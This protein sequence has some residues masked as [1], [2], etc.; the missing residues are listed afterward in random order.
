MKLKGLG[1]ILWHA[2][3]M[4]YHILVGLVWAWYLRERWGEFNASWIVAAVVGSVLPDADHLLYF[5]GYGKNDGYNRQIA[6]FVKARQWRSLT[7]FLE[8]GHKHN[9]NLSFHNVYITA[10]FIAG[11]FVASGIDWQF[12]VVLL[13]AICSHFL[14]DMFDDIVQLGALNTNWKRWGRQKSRNV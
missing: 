9:T 4:A 12:A 1:F 7:V 11:S 13:G 2:R 6:A 14:F 3:H 10:M 5:F 8:L